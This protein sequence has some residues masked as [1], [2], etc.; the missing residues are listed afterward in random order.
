[1]SFASSRSTADRP[2][3]WRRRLAAATE[4]AA[5]G[6]WGACVSGM[7]FPGMPGRHVSMI[8]WSVPF[9]SEFRESRPASA[10]VAVRRAPRL[11][12]HRLRIL[13]EEENIFCRPCAVEKTRND[14]GAAMLSPMKCRF[15][16]PLLSPPLAS[17]GVVF[18]FNSSRGGVIPGRAFS[19][20]VP[21]LV[22]SD[23]A[24]RWRRSR[25]LAVGNACDFAIDSFVVTCVVP[26]PLL[27]RP[28][29][30]QS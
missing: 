12:G 2:P 23:Q 4:F 20:F 19:W 29:H 22:T 16:G 27:R 13:R 1:M 6:P 15:K 5:A 14:H 26:S 25:R 24:A 7:I 3:G 11:A 30:R 21:D 28:T 9:V 10:S 18:A 8:G 17:C